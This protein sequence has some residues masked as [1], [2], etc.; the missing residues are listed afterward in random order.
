MSLVSL[1]YCQFY[2]HDLL[3]RSNNIN[4]CRILVPASRVWFSVQSGQFNDVTLRDRGNFPAT[5][6]RPRFRLG[7]SGLGL[8]VMDRLWRGL[9]GIKTKKVK[10]AGGRLSSWAVQTRASKVWVCVRFNRATRRFRRKKIERQSQWHHQILFQW[11]Q[12]KDKMSHQYI[13][14]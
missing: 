4:G 3:C 10:A 5:A 8:T 12:K 1:K 6:P 14:I 9:H 13:A 7:L 2:R 11:H